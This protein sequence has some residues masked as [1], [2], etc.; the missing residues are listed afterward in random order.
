MQQEGSQLKAR[1]RGL[2]DPNHIGT[3]AS[4]FSALRTVKKKGLCR[5]HLTYALLLKQ[6]EL[7]QILC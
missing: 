3:L 6:S 1:Q 2:P 5:S 7:K 4:E